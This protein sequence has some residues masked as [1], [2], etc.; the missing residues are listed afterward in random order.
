MHTADSSSPS[1]IKQSLPS[2]RIVLAPAGFQQQSG[3]SHWWYVPLVVCPTGAVSH[4]CC[5]TCLCHQVRCYVGDNEQRW[6]MWYSGN[7]NLTPGL[8]GVA[9]A[10]GSI[11]ES[12]HA[13]TAS[14]LFFPLRS[15]LRHYVTKQ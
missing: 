2:L 3:V 13:L 4:W 9:P 8:L 12:G 11:G 6:Y 15:L 14:W 1:L 7:S 10:A 5:V